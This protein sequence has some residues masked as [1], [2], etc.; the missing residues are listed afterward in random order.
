[1][2]AG[3]ACPWDCHWGGYPDTRYT[4][5]SMMEAEWTRVNNEHT[6]Q[7]GQLA[8]FGQPGQLEIPRKTK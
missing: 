3:L 6:N 5:K 1:M 4:A 8:Q 2:G 7:I